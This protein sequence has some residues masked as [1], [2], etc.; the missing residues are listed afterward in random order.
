MDGSIPGQVALIQ[1][2][3]EHLEVLASVPCSEVFNVVLHRTQQ[4]IREIAKALGKSPAAVSVHIDSLVKIGLVLESGTQ[5]RRSRIERLFVL[6]AA[7]NRFDSREHD[8]AGIEL[9]LKRFRGQLRKIERDFELAQRA[10]RA[11]ETFRLFCT[12][13]W[14]YVQ[15]SVENAQK[16]R[17]AVSDLNDMISRLGASQSTRSD[18]EQIRIWVSQVMIPS[19]SESLA[20]LAKNN[21]PM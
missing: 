21:T 9:F 15:L 8:W 10:A 12:Y 1:L 7:F 16:V 14:S 17:D 13:R 5:K 20:V 19:A 6:K 11:D 3:K 2:T 4:S 18:E